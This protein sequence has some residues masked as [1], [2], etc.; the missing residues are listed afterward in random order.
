MLPRAAAIC[1]PK[2]AV[3]PPDNLG[4]HTATPATDL[5]ARCVVVPLP[6]VA[7]LASRCV[8]ARPGCHRRRA[9]PPR[10]G[11][12]PLPLLAGGLAP[13]A[14]PAPPIAE[15]LAGVAR[16]GRRVG[17]GRARRLG[18][19]GRASRGAFGARGGCVAPADVLP[20]PP[21]TASPLF[22]AAT[23]RGRHPPPR[24]RPCGR[25]PR[26]CHF[27]HRLLPSSPRP[28]FHPVTGPPIA[29]AAAS[30]GRPPARRLGRLRASWRPPLPRA[31]AGC[32][33]GPKSTLNY[34]QRP[35]ARVVL[36]KA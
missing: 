22:A 29:V 19:G 13:P 30:G 34:F 14:P 9:L 8:P 2:A 35:F 23:A 11:A 33:L 24:G 32:A 1:P 36:N 5:C 6:S 15:R 16:F 17:W 27:H 20:L 31:K 28:H 26:R 12:P 18:A 7:A 25:P 3:A 10:V 21:P 4:P